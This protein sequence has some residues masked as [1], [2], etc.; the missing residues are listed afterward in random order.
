MNPV[1]TPTQLRLTQD[2]LERA[3]ALIEV[4]FLSL[5]PCLG[6]HP[7]SVLRTVVPMWYDARA[8]VSLHMLQRSQRCLSVGSGGCAGRLRAPDPHGLAVSAGLGI[9]ANPIKRN[10]AVG[11]DLAYSL[12]RNF[13]HPATTSAG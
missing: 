6:Y 5:Y 12:S 7:A 11:N 4:Q 13:S 2:L 8:R 1:K 3:D 10:D 9:S